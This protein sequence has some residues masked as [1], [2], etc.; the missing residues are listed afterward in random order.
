MKLGGTDFT[1][2]RCARRRGSHGGETTF[3]VDHFAPLLLT[4]LLI[5]RLI[6][7]TA[8]PTWP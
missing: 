3:Q 4:I 7:R 6:E 2:R 8:R 5:D 1:V